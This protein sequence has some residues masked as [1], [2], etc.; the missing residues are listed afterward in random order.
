MEDWQKYKYVDSFESLEE[1]LNLERCANCFNCVLSDKA[2]DFDEFSDDDFITFINGYHFYIVLS[3]KFYLDNKD[4]I[5]RRLITNGVERKK[6][7]IEFVK[8][9][10]N[11][12]DI[13]KDGFHF[14]IDK[15]TYDENYI[16]QLLDLSGDKS[17]VFRF[18]SIKPN[19]NII[20]MLKEYRA[21]IIYTNNKEN[22]IALDRTWI[23]K[24]DYA[25]WIRHSKIKKEMNST[26][27]EFITYEALINSIDY[28]NIPEEVEKICIGYKTDDYSY[29]SVNAGIKGYTEYKYEI[30]KLYLEKVYEMIGILRARG[31][32]GKINVEC[33]S[34]IDICNSPFSNK[35]ENVTLGYRELTFDEVEE[36]CKKLANTVDCLRDYAHTTS[37]KLKYI[38][39]TVQDMM[40]G[41]HYEKNS[42]INALLNSELY[43]FF[44]N[45]LCKLFD[46]KPIKLP[47]P[48][49]EIF[50]FF[51]EGN[52]NMIKFNPYFTKMVMDDC[53]ISLTDKA[54]E[55]CAWDVIYKML[56]EH[57][58][59]EFNGLEKYLWATNTDEIINLFVK[60]AV[61]LEFDMREMDPYIR[62]I[63]YLRNILMCLSE[64]DYLEF[65]K[66]PIDLNTREGID[67]AVFELSYRIIENKNKIIGNKIEKN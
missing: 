38:Y 6:R 43:Y 47:G 60:S 62:E 4:E 36:I 19:A 8:N 25:H 26:S 67:D 14:D 65:N 23:S 48:G 13:M 21:A 35:L 20:N 28:L 64:N 39:F 50:Y 5:E 41:E 34:L 22:T 51:E 54:K 52:P 7:N 10:Q 31:Y 33:D 46:L 58:D 24:C 3:R 61:P 30:N 12:P 27:D 56:S 49:Y 40:D 16:K 42:V 2:I 44:I 18:H 57:H 32:K 37:G 17:T 45:D 29:L 9:T 59:E 66:L 15:Y 11:N 1:A 55:D 53:K 63:N